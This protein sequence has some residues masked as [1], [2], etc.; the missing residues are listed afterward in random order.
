M[1]VNAFESACG[2]QCL[3]EGGEQIV[4]HFDFSLADAA[5]DVVV[6]VVRDLIG[7]VPAPGVGRPH[8]SVLCEEFQSAV[9]GR[10]GQPG[11]FRESL[12][13]DIS[14]REMG[15]FMAKHMQDRQPL[16]R[17]TV[18]TGTELGGV[19]S[20]TGHIYRYC[21][22]LQQHPVYMTA[23]VLTLKCLFCWCLL[24]VLVLPCRI[25]HS[26]F[27]FLQGDVCQF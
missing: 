8:Q 19:I 1:A 6:V 22:F 18:A 3:V 23:L 5:D 17:H 12:F 9:D 20:G 27:G 16:R 15:P 14:R 2:F 10:F 4:F 7:Q 11:Q 13:V 24:P 25:G 26:A 21:K